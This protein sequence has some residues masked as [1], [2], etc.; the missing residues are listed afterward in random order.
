MQENFECF[1]DKLTE[2]SVYQHL[3]GI[4]AKLHRGIKPELKVLVDEFEQRLSCCHG[5]GLE[6]GD[7]GQLP[8]LPTAKSAAKPVAKKTS[9]VST[10]AGELVTPQQRKTRE[11]RAR[12]RVTFSSDES[13]EEEEEESEEDVALESKTPTMTSPIRRASGG[14]RARGRG[15]DPRGERSAD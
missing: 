15:G 8:P 10:Q 5:R 6:G 1:A 13:S 9:K 7:L 4:A 12:V 3:M 2:E 14:R 11:P